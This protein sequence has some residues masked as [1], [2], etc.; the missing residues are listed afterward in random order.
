[1]A[2]AFGAGRIGAILGPLAAGW[3]LVRGW[4]A[5][6]VLLAAAL[7]MIGAAAVMLA[8]REGRL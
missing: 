1:V 3:L 7:P 6:E 4:P 2:W 5:A 8:L